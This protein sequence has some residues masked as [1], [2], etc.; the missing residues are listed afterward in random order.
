[1]DQQALM[2]AAKMG[3][4]QLGKIERGKHQRVYASTLQKLADGLGVTREELM[5]EVGLS[6]R[7]ATA[8][9]LWARAIEVQ[10]EDEKI[11]VEQLV[12]EMLE[13][14]KKTRALRGSGFPRIRAA[15][16]S[17]EEGLG[18]KGD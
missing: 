3:I 9:P 2:R 1:M 16:A 5:G 8:V 13:Q 10:A 15:A 14:R 4:T 18:K 11:A 6:E 12:R 7:A 17:K